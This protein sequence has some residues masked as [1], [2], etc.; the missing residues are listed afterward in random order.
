MQETPLHT[1]RQIP[2]LSE[3]PVRQIVHVEEI[4]RPLPRSKVRRR[5]LGDEL[6]P[7]DWWLGSSSKPGQIND[8]LVWLGYSAWIH[9]SLP[10]SSATEKFH[11]EFTNPEDMVHEQLHVDSVCLDL[12]GK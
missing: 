1:R 2:N 8:D 5:D 6:Q 3:E 9:H 12:G 10:N 11:T 7:L 4:Y